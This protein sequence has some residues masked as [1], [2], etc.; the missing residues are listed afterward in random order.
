LQV[1]A[2]SFAPDRADDRESADE[3]DGVDAG[4]KESRG[5]S[6][7][8]PGYDAEQSVAAMSDGGVS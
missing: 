3:C 5:K 7:A 6:F 8:A 4:V 2:T 1:V